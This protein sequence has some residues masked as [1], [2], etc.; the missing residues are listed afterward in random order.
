M[1]QNTKLSSSAMLGSEKD[2]LLPCRTT[3]REF[4]KYS[5]SP[6]EIGGEV[7]TV[8]VDEQPLPLNQSINTVG[9]RGFQADS[10]T[11]GIP[12]KNEQM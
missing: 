7:E 2:G 9:R 1:A 3:F 4:S 10:W 8:Y 12:A 6:C 5:G 11:Q